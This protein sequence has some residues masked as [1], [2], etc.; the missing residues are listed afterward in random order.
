[1]PKIKP[2]RGI[3]PAPEYVDQ[4]VLQLENLSIPQAKEIREG[5]PLSY[6]NMLVPRLE[7]RFMM[8][9][10][11]ELA[12]KQIN[13]N[14]EE[15]LE[16][17]ILRKDKDPSLYIYR[18]VQSGHVQTGIWAA[19][20]IDDYLNN[21]VKK[22][23]LTRADREAGLIEYLQHTDL[24]GNPVLITYPPS[25]TIN[26]VID[27]VTERNADIQFGIDG[28]QH[29]LWQI[30][31]E[32]Q[33]SVLVKAFGELPASYIADGHHRAAAACIAGIQRRKLN[34]KHRGDEEYNYFMSVY[35]ATDQ[36]RIYGFNRL[37]KDLGTLTSN[38]FFTRVNEHFEVSECFEKVVPA[39]IHQF[40]MYIDKK[41]FLLT[42]REET[43]KSRRPVETLD[44]SILQ[45]NVLAPILGIK[46]PRSDPRI[47][48][49]G[50]LIPVENLMSQVDS[51]CYKI[52]FTLFP[53]SI[54]ELIQVANCGEVMP[55]KSTWFEPK[56]LAGLLI[57]SIG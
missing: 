36:L 19:T 54:D 18:T 14:F 9:S 38:E 52:A 32:I 8:G 48:F 40:G 5:N 47:Q 25:E 22:H 45:E 29:W 39:E 27:R 28:Q 20:S 16:K 42:A 17:G 15:F 35:M 51:G 21:I 37:V 41:W 11:K 55:P 4:V 7:N 26:A 46:D 2:F 34:L 6:V 1:M 57:H 12:Y 3:R 33:I 13:E 43:Y 53:T 50:G 49:S 56:F 10:K 44:V 31:D 30:N 24:D 23:E